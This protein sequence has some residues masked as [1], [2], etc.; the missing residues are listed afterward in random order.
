MSGIFEYQHTV[1]DDEIDGHGHV[2]NLVYLKWM[3]TAA[4]SHSENLGWPIA[5][6]R[7]CGI[8]WVA[9][10]HTIDYLK[11]AFLDQEIVVQTWISNLRKATSVRKYHIRRVED[12]TLLAMAE[13]EW[14]FVDLK[15]HI[16]RRV[17][18]EI[19]DAFP[20]VSPEN[21]PQK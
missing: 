18:V 20:I 7:E 16:P 14:A 6:Y 13:T 10:K 21:E 2:N 17:P 9:R 15:Q 4:V 3:Q 8:G 5:R 12:Q 19:R 11:P 1:L